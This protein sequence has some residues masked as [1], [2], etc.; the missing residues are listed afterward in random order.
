MKKYLIILLSCAMQ[1]LA[2]AQVPPDYPI[3]PANSGNIVAIEYFVDNQQDFGTGTAITGYTQVSGDPRNVIFNGGINLSLTP[4]FHRIYFRS[5]DANG[6]WSQTSSAFFDNYTVPV[7]GSLPAPTNITQVEYFIDTDPGFGNGTQVSGLGAVTDI[8]NLNVNVDVTGLSNAVHTIYIR[9]K[10]ANGK[11]SITNISK[12]DKSAVVNYPT[13]PASAG[14]IVQVEYFIDNDP[15][16]G[17]GT[18]V[19]LVGVYQN[20]TDINGM[21]VNVDVSALSQAVHNI[22]VRSKDAGGKWSLA[23]ISKFDKSAQTPYPSAPAA[24]ADLNRVEYFIDT[25]PGFGNATAFAVITG[26]NLV[27]TDSIVQVPAGLTPGTHQ[28]FVR[29]K[30]NKWSITNKKDFL[31]YVS[32]F[33][34]TPSNVNFGSVA[35]GVS[36]LDSV[37]IKNVSTASKT[38]NSISIPAPFTTNFA[39]PVTLLPNESKKIYITFTPTAQL[40]YSNTMTITTSDGT[41]TV[42]LQGTGVLSAPA[43]T[44][45]Y[46]AGYDFGN[47]QVNNNGS[48]NYYLQNT[49]N[50]LLTIQSIATGNPAFTA[51]VADNNLPIGT[52][53]NILVNFAPTAIQQYLGKLEVR[54]TI[55]NL[56]SVTSAL[57]GFGYQ[58]GVLPLVKFDNIA[59]Y[60]NIRGVSPEAGPVGNYTYR[61]IYKSGSNQPPFAGYPKVAIDRNAD[62]DFLDADEG[63]FT[64]TKEGTSTDYITGVPYVYTVTHP[65]LS[66][67]LGYSFFAKDA[68]GNDATTIDVTY[69]TG[70]V[71]TNQL[72]DL[73]IFANDITFSNSNPDPNQVFSVFAR[74]SNAS[75]FTASNVPVKFYKDSVLLDSA[76]VANIP[77]YGTSTITKNLSFPIDGFYPIKVW[78]DSSNTLGET[79]VLN[80][81][82]IRPVTVGLFSVPG[83]I[84]ATTNATVQYCPLGIL[85]KG[86]AQYYGTSNPVQPKVAGGEVKIIVGTDTVITATNANG[87]YSYL[88]RTNVTCGSSVNFTYKVSITDFTFTTTLSPVTIAVPCATEPCGSTGLSS[89]SFVAIGTS[90]PNPCLTVQGGTFNYDFTVHYR[91]LNISNFWN[92]QDRILK[93]TTRL[94]QDGVKIFEVV[95]VGY[96]PSAVATYSVPVPLTSLGTSTFTVQHKY[97]YNEY[98]Q[99][100]GPF[101]HGVFLQFDDISSSSIFV[102]TNNPDLTLQGFNQ[103]TNSNS[104]TVKDYNPSC[105][106]AGAHV[107]NIYD[108]IPGGSYTLIATRNISSVASLSDVLIGYTFGTNAHG[109]HYLKIITDFGNAILEKDENNNT[110][111][112]TMYIPYAD[113]VIDSVRTSNNNL[114]V[115]TPVNFTAYVKN[116]KANAGTFKVSFTANGVLIGSKKVVTSLSGNNTTI[117]VAS[118]VYTVTNAYNSCPINIV[119]SADVDAQVQEESEINNDAQLQ[120]GADIKPY[121]IATDTGSSSLRKRVVKDIYSKI[122]VPIRNVGARQATNVTVRFSLNGQVI[123]SDVVPVV[124]A[125]INSPGYASFFYTFPTVGDF[126]IKVLADTANSICEADETNNEQ[127]FF[128]TVIDG[129]PDYLVLSQY[130]SPSNLN[131]NPGQSI[132]LVGTVKNI[133]DKISNNNFMRFMV[134]NV[135]VGADVPINSL[136]PG[137]DTTVQAT[138]TYVSATVGPKI[139]K[140][141]ADPTAIEVE[142]REDNNEATRAIIVGNAP[143]FARAQTRGIRFNPTG[144]NVGD[145]VTVSNFIRNYGGDGGTAW[146]RIIVKD[147]N[148]NVV[149]LDSV[150]FTIGAIDSAIVSK[151]IKMNVTKGRVFTEIVR[152]NPMEFNEFNNL[153]SVNFSSFYSLPAPRILNVNLNM[154][155]GL[156]SEFP[157]WVGG[158]LFLGNN[159]LTING[160]ITGFDTSHFIVTNGTGRL[161]IVNSNPVDTFP[162]GSNATSPNFMVINNTG[163]PDN[164]SVN[165]VD[166]VRANGTTGTAYGTQ[167]VNRTWD[168]QEETPGGSNSTLTFFWKA[169]AELPGFNRSQ[170]AV[171]HYENGIWVAGTTGVATA[172]SMDMYYKS[173]A[174]FTSFSPFIISSGGVFVLP[175]RLLHFEAV[176]LDQA[177]QLNWTTSSE[178]NMQSYQVEHSVNGVQFT[179]VGVLAARNNQAA[180]TYSFKHNAP[181]KGINYYRLKMINRDGSFTYSSVV[182][183]NFDGQI[184]MQVY[185][186]PTSD[187]VTI[188]GLNSKGQ[189]KLLS[190]EGKVLLLK[191]VSAQQMQISLK[192]FAGGTYMLQYQ[193]GEEIKNFKIIRE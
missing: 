140:I 179:N 169:N 166:S 184:D 71:I 142:Y 70:P 16:F 150:L 177:A 180:Y 134:D 9:S 52:G 187:I 78:I 132:T 143:D 57:K 128:I 69:K 28:I 7:Y 104:F 96:G 118:D 192:T 106:G 98:F 93:D 34:V 165:V 162:V 110:L 167:S 111:L 8:A 1:L 182:K 2:Q 151:K 56:D 109:Y 54:A 25:D 121:T 89:T 18:Q 160:S 95:N 114:P 20:A 3:A 42:A 80:N 137:Q 49:G 145:S 112:A 61:I 115:G 58:P 172:G 82:A 117:A 130:I 74:I 46:A 100:E 146:M 92:G 72:L 155:N 101:Y 36:K 53:K 75:P 156:P 127:D 129:K 148:G 64:M 63:M 178:S 4:G 21:P 55:T 105:F 186:N 161:K 44:L 79:N 99:I 175:L 183:L 59:P 22:Y 15:G 13:A 126:T 157:E 124:F 190:M 33:T 116:T 38:V 41:E 17:S 24:A 68:L 133:G 87:D 141:I 84:N 51:T 158:L 122:V 136:V 159:D 119:A 193:D 40:F 83:G 171:G 47:V 35:V 135:Q 170:C 81:Y 19:P 91:D 85:I 90:N 181:A 139:V 86:T 123:G 185:P 103:P 6:Y 144:F 189:I 11:W 176:K 26:N 88:Y 48:V 31:V 50:V 67:N 94:F 120:L 97:V 65:S 73:R 164:Y 163:T 152:S 14:N 108:S 39:T 149:G 168:I 153:D 173:Q 125:G 188:S 77:A 27:L 147:L 66:S 45:S 60:N 131:P 76:V 12:F 5:K 107:V 138:A 37:L 29:S 23:N 174:G 154:S 43:W 191:N 102:Q 113:L 32:P 30:N 10:E 62:Q